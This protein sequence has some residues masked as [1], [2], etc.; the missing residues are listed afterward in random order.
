MNASLVQSSPDPQTQG[1]PLE[2]GVSHGCTQR[3]TP[4]PVEANIAPAS[5]AC[6]LS[7]QS[8]VLFGYIYLFQTLKKISA[9]KEG[10]VKQLGKT[11]E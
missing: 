7:T 6:A 10:S 3:I 1:V 4:V 5:K 2:P 11:T 9:E 8:L